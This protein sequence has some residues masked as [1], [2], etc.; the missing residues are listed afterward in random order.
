MGDVLE[1]RRSLSSKRLNDLQ[2]H[3]E[4]TITLVRRKACVYATGSFARGDASQHSDLDLF[5]VGKGTVA[6]GRVRRKL[7]RLDETCIK[8]ELILATD[9][10]GIP[11]FSGD[12]E[13]LNHYTVSELVRA[14][15]TPSDDATNTFTA[16]LLLLLESRPIVGADVYQDAIESTVEAYWRDFEDHQEDFVPA[17]LANDILRLWRTFCVNYEART[18]KEPGLQKAKRKLKNHKLKHSRLLT[19]NSALLYLMHCWHRY[20]TVRP[21]HAVEM[22][23]LSPTERLEFLLAETRARKTRGTLQELLARYERFLEE[24]DA[25]ESAL[26]ARLQ[27]PNESGKVFGQPDEFARLMFDALESIGNRST[28]HRMLVV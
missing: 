25:R 22:A 13:Y 18:K 24:T 21:G 19:C 9:A 23:K 26:L 11:K 3:L 2:Q 27:D 8:A 20:R 4:K 17:F 7:S 6:A 10:M 15:G 12:G 16:R 5:I 1:R 14:L 28:F